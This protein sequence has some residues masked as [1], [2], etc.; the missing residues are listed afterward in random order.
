MNKQTQ[1]ELERTF[2]KLIPNFL[3]CRISEKRDNPYFTGYILLVGQVFT[4]DGGVF[5]FSVPVSVKD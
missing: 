5:D 1:T 4:Q 2:K 3:S